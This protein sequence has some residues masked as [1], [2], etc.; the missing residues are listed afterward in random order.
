MKVLFLPISILGGL[1]AGLLGKKIFEQ[2]WGLVDDQEPP[3][4]K[5]REVQYGK[6]AAALLLEGAIF[7]FIRGFFDHGARRGF[8]RLTGAWPGE[9]A[10]EPE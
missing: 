6:L 1:L 4:A 7:R 9:E 10:P 2:I 8:Q 3:A 5:H